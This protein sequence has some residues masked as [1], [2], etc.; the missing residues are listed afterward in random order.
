ME[1]LNS[2][3]S[4]A[5]Y[6]GPRKGTCGLGRSVGIDKRHGRWQWEQV[7]ACRDIS[8]Y[9]C[10][11]H[12]RKAKDAPCRQVPG[13]G[14]HTIGA[15]IPIGHHCRPTSTLY[16]P[17][18]LEMQHAFVR[19]IQVLL[20]LLD[21]KRLRWPFDTKGR[22]FRRGCW[23]CRQALHRSNVLR[24]RDGTSWELGSSAEFRRAGQDN[25]VLV[26]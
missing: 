10:T 7:W 21:G 13:G 12:T 8:K 23:T 4:Q 26:L 2:A 16:T 18:C 17:S 1:A 20:P 19:K 22:Y 14:F 11:P 24:L 25:K 6:V 15:P 3:A 5:Q 9:M